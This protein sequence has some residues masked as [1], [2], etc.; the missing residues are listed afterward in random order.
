[1][2]LGPSKADLNFTSISKFAVCI[3]ECGLVMAC[4]DITVYLVAV[5]RTVL[6]AQ[7]VLVAACAVLVCL[8]F[9]YRPFIYR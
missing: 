9:R 4:S 6:A 5:A 7:N 1:M 3:E 2:D 8:V